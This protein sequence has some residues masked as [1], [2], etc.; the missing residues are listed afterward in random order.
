M[1]SRRFTVQLIASDMARY[2]MLVP[3]LACPA[4]CAYCCKA[5]SAIGMVLPR[6]S[7]LDEAIIREIEREVEYAEVKQT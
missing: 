3:S 2:L 7:Q 5:A 1:R 4:D 6:Q